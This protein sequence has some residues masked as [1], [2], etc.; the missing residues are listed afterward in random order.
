MPSE[1]T[2]EAPSNIALIKYWGAED[3]GA[4]VPCNPSLSM[5]LDR[6]R[7]VCS[8]SFFEGDRR[9][10]EILLERDGALA[11][12]PESFSRRIAAH[13]VRLRT[14]WNRQGTL[15]IATRN[16]FPA[17]AGIASSASGFTA[18]TLAVSRALGIELAPAELS[19]WSRRSG[20]GSASRSAFGGYVQWPAPGTAD[21]ASAAP[22]ADAEHWPLCDL[23]AIVS[24]S[25]KEVSS[26]EGHQRAATSPYFRRRLELVPGRLDTVREAIAGRDF[27]RLADAVDEE[28]IDLH[29]IM[30]SSR[31]PI[32]YWR[33][34]TVAVLAEVRRLR[35]EGLAVCA[36]MD[37][38]PNVHVLCE[39][40]CAADAEA[41]LRRVEGVEEVLADRTGTGPVWR[42]GAEL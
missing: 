13:L 38:G 9:P 32:F 2:A 22:V 8:A 33:P 30:M 16:T 18:L 17:E 6:C 25:S 5:T 37:A 26:L 3:L 23:V 21:A 41:A 42:Q 40:Q 7:S 11:P 10:D 1:I 36:T 14:A 24:S 31:P 4:V 34:A 19:N 29:L 35:R 20:S 27:A 39:P 12:A 15:R 28:A